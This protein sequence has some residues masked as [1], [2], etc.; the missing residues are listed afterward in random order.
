MAADEDGVTVGASANEFAKG[1]PGAWPQRT[2]T[3][4]ASLAAEGNERMA[5]VAPGKF[6][7][8]DVQLYRL[9]DPSPGVVEEQQQGVFGSAPWCVAVGNREQSLHLV[10][11]DPGDRTRHGFLGCN[12][13]DLRA[14]VEMGRIAARDEAGEGAQ[15]RQAL[16]AG[17]HRAAAL[18]LEVGK[19][20][21]HPRR[22]EILDS[23]PVDRFASLV[24]DERE[25]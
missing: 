8:T 21:Q 5:G 25:Q 1:V 12:G 6:D 7:V 2:L 13:A 23:Q 20:L 9:R 15:R 10:A 14:P 19:E 18:L 3:D 4:L 24:A 17:L 11:G 22:R 16:V